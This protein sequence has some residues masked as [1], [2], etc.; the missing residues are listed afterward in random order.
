MCRKYFIKLQSVLEFLESGYYKQS[1]SSFLFS[2]RNKDNLASFITK[3]KQGREHYA[4]CCNSGYAPIFGGGHDLLICN[5]PQV[6]QSSS[7][8]GHTHQLP[9]GYVEGSKQAK[10]ILAGQYEFKITEIEVFN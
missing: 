4:I 1:S 10:N 9:L 7:M 5:N 3:I 6:N 8:F 2:L